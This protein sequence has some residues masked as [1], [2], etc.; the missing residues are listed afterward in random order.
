[1]VPALQ[2]EDSSYIGFSW[3]NPN[4]IALGLDG[5][6]L[7][8]Q[9]VGTGPIT[10][11]YATADDGAIVTSTAQCSTTSAKQAELSCLWGAS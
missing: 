3:G 6:V 11:L 2:R 4:L 9:T 7:W 10:P 5:S 8:Q 1:L